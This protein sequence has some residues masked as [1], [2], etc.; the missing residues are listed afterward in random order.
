MCILKYHTETL[1]VI[2]DKIQQ[3]VF[4]FIKKYDV[5]ASLAVCIFIL[6]NPKKFG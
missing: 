3:I 1:P 6:Y 4:F 2:I 5:S